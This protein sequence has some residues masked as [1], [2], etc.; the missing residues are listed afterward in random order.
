M[1]LLQCNKVPS[2][3]P[4]HNGDGASA[5][6]KKIILTELD[7]TE[8]EGSPMRVYVRIRDLDDKKVTEAY[9]FGYCAKDWGER[10]F[11]AAYL[12]GVNKQQFKV[13][14]LL[15]ARRMQTMRL[16]G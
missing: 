3:N 13:R 1:L 16:G 9:Q 2:D 12:K 6:L 11:T 14:A 5:L 7:E 8:A 10:W 15:L 4:D